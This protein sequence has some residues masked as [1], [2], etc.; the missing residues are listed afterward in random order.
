MKLCFPV[1]KDLGIN[2][3]IFG[4][5]SSAPLFLIVDTETR[6][7]EAVANSDPQNPFSGCNPFAALKAHEIDGIIA[8]GMGDSVLKAMNL[9]GC[10]VYEAQ[11]ENLVENMDLF[12]QE[13]LPEC[14]VQNSAAAG[15]C[16]DDDD[17]DAEG[18]SGSETCNHS[19]EQ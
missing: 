4:H 15:R 10:R 13:K 3:N 5:F 8:G 16:S 14:V 12:N 18:S 19:D 11:S 9:C 1:P 17:D 2:S 6:E 7:S